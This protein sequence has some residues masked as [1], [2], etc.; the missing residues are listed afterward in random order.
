MAGFAINVQML[1]QVPDALFGYKPHSRVKAN[2][3][4]QETRFLENF[5][6]NRDDSRIECRG[7]DKEVSLV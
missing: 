6:T 1:L 4:W 2:G 7:S 5:A 3:G